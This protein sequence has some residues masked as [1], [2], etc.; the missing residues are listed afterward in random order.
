[1]RPPTTG[2]LAGEL[3]SSI[4]AH[5]VRVVRVPNPTGTPAALILLARYRSLFSDD[6]SELLA[7]LGAQT[8][9]VA[10]RRLVLADQQ[11][12]AEEKVEERLEETLRKIDGISKTYKKIKQLRMKLTTVPKVKKGPQ[13]RARWNLGRTRVELSRT[14]RSLD[15]SNIQKQRLMDLMRSTVEKVRPLERELTKLEAKADRAR[16]DAKKGIQKEIHV[17]RKQDRR[18]RGRNQVHG[19][20]TQADASDDGAGADPGGDR[21]ARTG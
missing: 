21:E 15:F 3:A 9:L 11:R 1:M 12:L 16:K 4:G 7:A 5:Y 20:G 13:V 19:A 2:E 6:D 18:N 10:E 17:I 14:I 8:A